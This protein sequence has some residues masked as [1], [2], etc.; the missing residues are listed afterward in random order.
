M[1]IELMSRDGSK[2]STDDEAPSGSSHVMVHGTQNQES[3]IRERERDGSYRKS[4]LRRL[5]FFYQKD[6]ELADAV[7]GDAAEIEFTAE[8]DREVRR[9]IDKRV[10]S[11]ILT[12]YLFN[13]FDRTNIGNAHVIKEFNDNFDITTNER[14]TLALS[15]FYIGY[16]QS[17]HF[18]RSID[19]MIDS[20]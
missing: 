16:C 2:D 1:S 10:L 9:K 5:F 18:E 6:D 3:L 12:S 20:S 13:Q 8:E 19:G 7:S 4:L 17:R 11:I 15:V 14:W